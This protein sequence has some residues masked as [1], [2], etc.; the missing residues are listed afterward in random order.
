MIFIQHQGEHVPGDILHDILKE[1]D[2]NRNGQVELD[3]YL[4]VIISFLIYYISQAGLK[5]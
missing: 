5:D 2:T 1:L 4:A 3:E